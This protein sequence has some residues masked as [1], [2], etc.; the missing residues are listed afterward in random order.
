MRR[1]LIK[2]EKGEMPLQKMT[3]EGVHF[4]YCGKTLNKVDKITHFVYKAESGWLI[5]FTDRQFAVGIEADPNRKS[6]WWPGGDAPRSAAAKARAA[7]SVP[8]T[9]TSPAW[10]KRPRKTKKKQ[11]AQKPMKR[12]KRGAYSR[13]P[14]KVK[15]EDL[16]L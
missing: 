16:F 8:N 11:E 13:K 7:K 15:S 9:I 1:E 10:S 14:E 12:S 5:S 6:D 2:I 4:T 3:V